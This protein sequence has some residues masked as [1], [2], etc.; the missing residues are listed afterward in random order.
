MEAVFIKL[1]NMSI[2]ASYMVIIIA[3]LRLM[4]KKVPKWIWS[5][6]WAMVAIRLLIPFSMESVLSLMPTGEPVSPE[7]FQVSAPVLPADQPVVEPVPMGTSPVLPGEVEKPSMTPV[8]KPVTVPEQPVEESTEVSIGWIAA[9]VWAVGLSGMLMYALI[10]YLR[11]RHKVREGVPLKE[12]C[13]LCDHIGTPFILGIVRPRIYLPSDMDVG[14]HDYVIAHEMA[15]LKRKDHWWKPFGFFLLSVY[16][17]NPVIWLGYILLCCDIELACDERVIKELGSEQKKPYADALINCSASRRFISACPLAFG[18]GNVERRIKSVLNCKKPAFWAIMLSIVIC[19]A[20]AV[21][22]L[23]D[24]IT[25]KEG[26]MTNQEDASVQKEDEERILFELVNE[27]A[28]NPDAAMHSNPYRY[29]EMKQDAYDEI[30]DYGDTAVEYFV[31]YLREADNYGLQEYIM[32]AACSEITNIGQK[33]NGSGWATAGEWLVIYESWAKIPALLVFSMIDESRICVSANDYNWKYKGHT[34]NASDIALWQ[35]DY[36]ESNTLVVDGE[37]G[38]SELFLSSTGNIIGYQIYLP[39]GTVYDDGTREPYDSLSLRLMIDP[40]TG[41]QSLITP[42]QP[43]EYIYAVTMDY[44]EPGVVVTYGFKVIM[45]GKRCGND[46]ALDA[47]FDYYSDRDNPVI[48][49][50]QPLKVWNGEQEHRYYVYDVHV[51]ASV[52]C[53]AVS[54]D[55]KEIL[56]L[57]EISGNEMFF[58]PPYTV[59]DE[60]EYDIDGDGVKERG[61]LNSI[62]TSGV[63]AFKFS[64]WE[65]NK[66]EYFTGSSS[67]YSD[68]RF[69]LAGDGSLDLMVLDSRT[70]NAHFADVKIE[71]GSVVLEEYG[72]PMHIPPLSVTIIDSVDFDI[73]DDSFEETCSIGCLSDTGALIYEISITEENGKSKS[74]LYHFSE[75]PSGELYFQINED[76]DLVV[77]IENDSEKH[78]YHVELL[79]N[80]VVLTQNGIPVNNTD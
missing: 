68:I 13:Y 65:G 1:V 26:E 38:Q 58:L 19:I 17:F 34:E 2:S 39:D 67:I 25:E 74:N 62:G 18:E 52:E 61:V 54:A 33:T 71:S 64:F 47:V 49:Y 51:G 28:N 75:I 3:L 53:I 36:D 35:R 14:D 5:I 42:F 29:I 57:G 12:N 4:L 63:F 43:G 6:L 9:V 45:T 55:G 76:G 24:P 37:H 20:V 15:H 7:V 80:T 56:E 77:I 50:V 48:S 72:S 31:A 10:S 21:T 69:H 79:E 66:L 44:E 23:T 27:I 73:D 16:W 11:V 41:R 8:T 40:E 22:M 59:F 78:I 30:L 46:I 60:I 70:N 32:A